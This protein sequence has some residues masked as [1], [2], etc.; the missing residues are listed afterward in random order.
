MNEHFNL[1]IRELNY[2]TQIYIHI[3]ISGVC[4]GRIQFFPPQIFQI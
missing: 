4:W 2:L 3:R 1:I